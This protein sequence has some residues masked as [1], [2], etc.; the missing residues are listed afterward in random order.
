MK[1][2]VY[3]SPFRKTQVSGGIKVC[4]QH[5]EMLNEMGI[6][7]FVFSPDGYPTWFQTTAPL[8][9]PQ[10]R[11]FDLNHIAVFPEPVH[12]P[13]LL[14]IVQAADAAAKK[15]LFCQN[16]YNALNNALLNGSF[17]RLGFTHLMTV[18]NVAAKM[19]NNVFHPASLSVVQ[20]YIDPERFQKRPKEL[21]IA[22]VPR[23]MPSIF[24][25]VQRIFAAKFPDLG[26][27]VWDVVENASEEAVAESFGRAAVFLSLCNL[28]SLGITPLEAMASG[29]AV[30]GFHGYGGME[31]ATPHNGIWLPSDHLEET[32]DALAQVIRDFVLG[33]SR[34]QGLV[35]NGAL[36]AKRFNREQTMKALF[37]VYDTLV[38]S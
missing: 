7:A 8:F 34:Y 18:S 25:Y 13:G 36:T 4:F 32:A 2:I 9:D 27:V 35:A 31:Y 14:K 23:K 24:N 15:I 11:G 6:K 19:L 29:C 30:V 17:E 33:N 38:V 20:P 5:V 37:Q 22:V 1:T 10:G 3:I 26:G 16:Q 21:R 28:E 12:Q